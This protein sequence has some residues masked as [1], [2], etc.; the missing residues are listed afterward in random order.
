M[1]LDFKQLRAAHSMGSPFFVKLFCWPVL[2]ERVK[3]PES[4]FNQL[5]VV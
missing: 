2:F 3:N 4:I 5:I 1:Q